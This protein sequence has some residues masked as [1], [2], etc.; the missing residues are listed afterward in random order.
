VRVLVTGSAGFLGS[1]VADALAESGADVVGFD[2]IPTQGYPSFEGDLL[3]VRDLTEAMAGME[4]VCHLAAVGD[5]YLAAGQPALAASINV[6]GTAN[7]C[8]AA[9]KSGARVVLASTWEVYGEP[10][11]DPVDET[12]PCNPDHPYSITKLAGE[13]IALAYQ[14]LRG[15]KVAALRLGTAY[16][17]RMRPNSVFSVFIDRALRGEPLVIQGSGQQTR[18]FTHAS[19][20]GAAFV[21]ASLGASGVFNIVAERAV[22][23][24]ELAEYVAELIPTKVT[25]GPAR[26]GDVPSAHISADRA[27]KELGWSAKRDFLEGL[28]EIASERGY[29]APSGSVYAETADSSTVAPA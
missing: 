5:V 12:H 4:V 19:D 27:L 21:R 22:S 8:E 15:L 28:T 10:E 9:L 6:T 18:Q 24:A 13:R 14:H 16:G 2:R 20:I 29:T 23:I 1:H 17:T 3:S 26:P 11:R 25:Y 7:V